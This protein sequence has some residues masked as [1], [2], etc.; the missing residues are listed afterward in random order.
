MKESHDMETLESWYS[1]IVENADSGAP[2]CVILNKSDLYTPEELQTTIS[3]IRKYFEGRR[4]VKNVFAVTYGAHS[5]VCSD[6]DRHLGVL[7]SLRRDHVRKLQHREE[8]QAPTGQ[9]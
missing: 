2:I 1:L 3:A 5:G 8:E 4:E 6:R 9:L 7:Q